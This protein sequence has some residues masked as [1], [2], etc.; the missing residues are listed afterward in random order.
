MKEISGLAFFTIDWLGT[1]SL[2]FR[3]GSAAGYEAGLC[4]RRSVNN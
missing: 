4:P 2:L 3:C 1:K